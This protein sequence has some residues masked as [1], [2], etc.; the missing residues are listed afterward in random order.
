MR[1]LASW[2]GI[3]AV[4]AAALALGLRPGPETGSAGNVAQVAAGLRC[5]VCQ[6]LS[7]KDS[8]S[9]TARDMRADISRRLDAGETPT[10][11]R[12]AYVDRYGQWILLRPGTRGFEALV[13]AVPAAVTA[14]GAVVLATAFWRWR[15]R[16]QGR[17]PTDEERHLVAAA[18]AR[19][20]PG[21]V[22]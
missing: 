3:A 16:R 13:W 19:Y 9:P 11:I 22:P 8:D 4:V 7:V 5:P 1:R 17:V 18:A 14:A 15:S 21:A 6:G 10:E 2:A 20:D 12:R